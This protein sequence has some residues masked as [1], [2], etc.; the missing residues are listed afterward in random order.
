[1]VDDPDHQVQEQ[2]RPHRRRR[3]IQ[4]FSSP[5]SYGLVVLLIV[6][7][8]VLSATITAVWAVSLV[9]IRKSPVRG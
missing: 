7:T 1:M 9:L 8:Y 4:A 3:L 5:D 2:P 6:V